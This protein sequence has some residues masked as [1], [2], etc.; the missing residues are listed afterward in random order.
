ME[1]R[2]K[3]ESKKILLAKADLNFHLT[4]ANNAAND[5]DDDVSVVNACR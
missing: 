3:N 2:T 1:R 4:E 5:D